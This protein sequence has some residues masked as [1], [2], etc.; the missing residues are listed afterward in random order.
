MISIWMMRSMISISTITGEVSVKV[1][2]HYYVEVTID[3]PGKY[4]NDLTEMKQWVQQKYGMKSLPSIKNLLGGNRVIF[5]GEI[6][7][8]KHTTMTKL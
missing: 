5:V 6:S 8:I 4:P 7:P 3:F 1:T 2:A